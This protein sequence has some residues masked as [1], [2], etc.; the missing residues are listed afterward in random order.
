L[1]ISTIINND[2]IQ[3]GGYNTLLLL[4]STIILLSSD[5][6]QINNNVLL[7]YISFISIVFIFAIYFFYFNNIQLI[8]LHITY[9]LAGPFL[10]QNTT[11]MVLLSL[12]VFLVFLNKKYF[13]VNLLIAILFISIILTQSR[14]AM[15]SAMIVYLFI[16][17]KKI[18]III[19]SSPILIILVALLFEPFYHRMYIKMTE[20]GSSHRID[21]WLYTISNQTNSIIHFLFGNGINTTNIQHLGH[22][23]SVHSSYINFFANFG[24]ITLISLL[25]LIGY[26]LIKIYFFNKLHFIL[27]ISI[28]IHGMFE[29]TLFLGY[30]IMWITFIFIV[31]LSK[32]RRKCYACVNHTI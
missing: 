29:T 12:F 13:L 20:G 23:L 3:Q 18:L 25:A 10:N 15:L 14:S 22:T 28:L 4:F 31:I 19:L 5:I 32:T 30:N 1:L 26:I 7:K 11:A 24:L 9:V 6:K 16:Y 8:Q 21:F 17:R 27:L 2:I